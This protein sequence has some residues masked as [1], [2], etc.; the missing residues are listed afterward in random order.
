MIKPGAFQAEEKELVFDIDMMD[1]DEVRTCCKLVL[2]LH[3]FCL[4]GCRVTNALT[5]LFLGHS[6]FLD[7]YNDDTAGVD[8]LTYQYKLKNFQNRPL[9]SCVLS[10]LAFE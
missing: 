1:Y 6:D 5:D 9:Y 2:N 8:G 7:H 3:D 10:C 4:T